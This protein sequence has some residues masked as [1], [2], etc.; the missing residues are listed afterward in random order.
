VSILHRVSGAALFL[1]GIPLLLW[2]L[3]VSL[4]SPEGF[5]RMGDW[6]RHP[7]MKLLQIGFIWAFLHH[8]F[9]GLRFLALDLH[10][11]IGLAA[12]RASAKLVLIVSLALTLLIGVWIW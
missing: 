10:W 9:A 1:F 4:A 2:A 12:A 11:G 3:S 5:D 6:L 7:L 8:F